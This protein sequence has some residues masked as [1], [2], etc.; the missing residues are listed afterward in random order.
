MLVPRKWPLRSSPLT[1]DL[2]DQELFAA[3][4]VLC[5][6]VST[7]EKLP[8]ASSEACRLKYYAQ[9]GLT[10]AALLLAAQKHGCSI[11]TDDGPLYH[12]LHAEEASVIKF[13]ELLKSL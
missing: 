6:F 8:I 13:G 10:D 4:R 3:R 12:I 5:E 11:I 7:N 9:F 2:K 1:I